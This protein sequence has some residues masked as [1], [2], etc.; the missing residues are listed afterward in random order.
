[1]IPSNARIEEKLSQ[2]LSDVVMGI[3]GFGASDV[4]VKTN[5]YYFGDT[6]PYEILVN[7][8]NS[9]KLRWKRIKNPQD[10]MELREENGEDR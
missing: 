6:T 2:A 4:A 8:L 5:L 10:I 1:M 9:M 3:E 7:I